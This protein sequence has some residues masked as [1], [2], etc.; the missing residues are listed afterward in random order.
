MRPP[1]VLFFDV[2][3]TLLDLTKLKQSVAEAL[4]GNEDLVSLWFTTMLQYSL[5]TTV[6]HKYYNFGEIGAASLR[7]VAANYGHH[8]S[9][10]EAKKVLKPIRSL[11][12]HPEVK[13]AL[14]R[15]KANE[16]KMIALTNSSD[17]V[18]REQLE[19]AD[20]AQFFDD[21]LSVEKAGKY[22]PHRDVYHWAA[23]KAQVDPADCMM[24]AA[25]GWDIAGAIWAGFMGAFIARPEQQRYLLAPKP[26]IDETDLLKVAN[27]LIALK[28]S[29]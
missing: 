19:N 4:G 14:S 10:E 24:I 11:P 23:S 2:N 26:E 22:K 9:D 27:T 8:L 21:N 13:E 15:L 12:A 17:E 16:F 28:H 29:R 18:M 7:M 5:V 20:L 3:E 6:S 1:K 25:H